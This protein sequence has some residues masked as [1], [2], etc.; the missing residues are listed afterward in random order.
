MGKGGVELGG[1]SE[2]PDGFEGDVG[3]DEGKEGDPESKVE[4]NGT[5]E[6]DAEGVLDLRE[7]FSKPDGKSVFVHLLVVFAVA[8]VVDDENCSR[9]KSW[10]KA[11]DGGLPGEGEGL[12]VGSC[13]CCNGAKKEEDEEFA[14]A[15]VGK[16][17]G[18]SSVADA[19][20]DGEGREK[21]NGGASSEDQ[22][23]GE[24]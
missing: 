7:P 13:R 17:E 15:E 22:E 11:E 12:E 8:Q 4:R 21:S 6:E 19:Q 18:T 16:G 14:K 2:G 10:G 20:K 24:E 9:E 1:V 5:A 23:D 3:G